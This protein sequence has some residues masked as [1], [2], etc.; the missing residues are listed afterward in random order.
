MSAAFDT[1]QL[2]G[3][4]LAPGSAGLD[5][6]LGLGERAL[7]ACQDRN[8]GARFGILRGDREAQPLAAAGNHRAP[9]IQSN[10]HTGS[11]SLGCD[12]DQAVV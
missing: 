11:P 1:S 12:R 10:V 7:V 9:S 6:G 3:G 8:I 2:N 4:D 5:L